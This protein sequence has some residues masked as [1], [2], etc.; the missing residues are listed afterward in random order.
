MP[1]AGMSSEPRA[2]NTNALAVSGPGSIVPLLVVET[3]TINAS[4]V[5]T[6]VFTAAEAMQLYYVREVHSTVS[7][8]GVL[9]IRKCTG[10]TAPASGTAC[11]SST[12]S[13]SS[14]INTVQSGTLSAT[15]SDYTLAAG[16]R[17]ALTF[18]GTMTGLVGC[19]TIYLRRVNP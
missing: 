18:T 8:S 13:L 4:S 19:V 7:T 1:I 5:D 15:A 11:L 10:T 12:I 17:L 16:D 2:G 14:T 9:Q 3:F 6:I